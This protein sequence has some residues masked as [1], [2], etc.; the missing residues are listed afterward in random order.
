MY[1]RA[2]DT[3]SRV[4][5]CLTL[6]HHLLLTA[7]VLA[8]KFQGDYFCDNRF[9]RHRE[10]G[11]AIVDNLSPVERGPQCPTLELRKCRR[12]R[13][14]LTYRKLQSMLRSCTVTVPKR[15]EKSTRHTN[16]TDSTGGAARALT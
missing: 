15:Q 2:F 7:V 5:G 6:Y 13:C 10:A 14:H 3:L 8:A 12:C 9:T 11:R 1:T 16:C 4:Y